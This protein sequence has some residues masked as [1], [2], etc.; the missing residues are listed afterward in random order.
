MGRDPKNIIASTAYDY[1]FVLDRYNFT[2]EQLVAEYANW[3]SISINDPDNFCYDSLVKSILGKEL[4]FNLN[5]IWKFNPSGPREEVKF[6]I[7]SKHDIISL[8]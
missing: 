4:K 5:S 3:S 2:I 7:A 6:T 8:T 1:M